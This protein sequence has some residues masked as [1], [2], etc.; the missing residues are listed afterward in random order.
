MVNTNGR[1][2]EQ[3]TAPTFSGTKTTDEGFSYTVRGELSDVYQWST[4]SGGWYHTGATYFAN[5]A[6]NTITGVP[7]N[8]PWAF[9]LDASGHAKTADISTNHM[10]TNTTYDAAGNPLVI[11]FNTTDPDTYSYDPNTE[12]LISYDFQIGG[13]PKHFTGTLSWNANGTLN[14]LTVV[15]GVNA[16]A[17]SEVCTYGRSGTAGYDPIGRLVN[18]DCWNG[19]TAVWGQAFTYDV[20]NNVKKTVPTGQTGST[21]S[22]TYSS[23]TNQYSTATYDANGNILTDGSGNTYIWNQDDHVLKVNG[24][25]ASNYDA[26]GQMIEWYSAS[27]WNQKLLSPVGVVATMKGQALNQ[28]RMP[29][30]GGSTVV[31]GI[32]F[33][34]ADG[35]GSVPLISGRGSRASVSARLFAPYGE[36]YNNT[37]SANNL[38]F[39]GDRQDL[40]AGN[41]TRNVKVK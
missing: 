26:A 30:P 2:A 27:V 4:H 16:G 3:F 35:L 17:D 32:N 6:T 21:W 13:T 8:T 11:T 37:G 31:P 40:V 41:K 22:P 19:G 5:G 15:D 29:L 23:T 25:N 36:S 1:V 20:Y 33:E 10:V 34:H 39:T 7:G 14:G 9:G 12:R 24:G 18:V 38:I 28:Y